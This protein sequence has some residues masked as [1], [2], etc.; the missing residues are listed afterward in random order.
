M[1]GNAEGATDRVRGAAAR[2][3]AAGSARL[4][5]GVRTG[6]PVA[7][8]GDWVGEGVVDFAGRR[9]RVSQL[10]MP[11]GM[12]EDISQRVR[13]DEASPRMWDALLRRR[14]ILYDGANQLMNADGRWF[15]HRL[16]DRDGPRHHTDPLWP[17]DA[18]FGAGDG[19]VELEEE[20]VRDVSTVRYRLTV[21]LAVADAFVPAGITVPEGSYRR[22]RRLPAEVWLDGAGLAR[23]IAIAKNSNAAEERHWTLT[24]FWDF[25][26]RVTITPPD[27]DQIL[28]AADE[29]DWLQALMSGGEHP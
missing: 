19:V 26:T 29:A 25:G 23:R 28:T 1:A 16:N 8:E 18:L 13:D 2:T 22:L 12:Q 27:P 9:A 6:S 7:E 24:E 15:V 10:L 20:R 11:E 3:V 21:D 14:E 5:F 4:A 17:L